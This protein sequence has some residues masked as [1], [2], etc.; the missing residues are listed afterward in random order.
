MIIVG[1]SKTETHS[2][3]FPFLLIFFNR[4]SIEVAAISSIGCD[5]TVIEGAFKYGN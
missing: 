1:L 3:A 2:G 4:S 5:A